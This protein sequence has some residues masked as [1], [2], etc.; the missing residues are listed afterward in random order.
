M[1]TAAGPPPIAGTPIDPPL[2]PAPALAQHLDRSR[3]GGIGYR[4]M[5][6]YSFAKVGLLA[7]GTAYYCFLALLSLLAFTYG[8]VAIIGADRIAAELT[9]SLADTLPGLVGED[10]IDPAQ[11]QATG[12]TAGIVGLV[13]MLYSSL[14]A[15][16]GA[17]SSLH[18][19]Y[20]APP[21]PRNFVKAKARSMLILLM[22][23]P[24][25]ALSFVSV[26]ATSTLIGPLLEAVGLD[27]GPAR[28]AIT[29]S[30]LVVG[31]LLDVLILWILLGTLGGIRPERRPRLIAA[32]IGAV[33][34]MLIKQLLEAIIA[35]SLDKPQYGAF[36]IPLAILFLFSLLASV[37]YI[38]A[39][40]VAGI[41]DADLP[42]E[43]YG[44]GAADTEGD[45]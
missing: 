28:L 17:S 32:A 23:V 10:G 22:V 29:L 25:I 34:V 9:E 19:V 14:G 31:Y 12:A 11:L 3:V 45:A 24:L 35:W 27:S 42:L 2:P 26:A 20:G 43:A 1:S 16:G 39:A 15:V 6:R 21:D 30:G 13:L 8:V 7:A 4:A 18:V 41:S 5:R 40:I 33:G 44:G 37:L 38:S 36:A